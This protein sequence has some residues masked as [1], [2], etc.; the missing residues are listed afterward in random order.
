VLV[1]AEVV[2]DLPIRR[3]LQQPLGQLLKQAA[4]TGQLQP[5][6]LGPV[7]ELADQLLVQAARYRPER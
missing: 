2:G 5:A 1:I 7:H 4:L 6:G 3:L